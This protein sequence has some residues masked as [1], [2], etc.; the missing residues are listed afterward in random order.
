[1][2]SPR[3]AERLWEGMADLIESVTIDI[4]W[5]LYG[6]YYQGFAIGCNAST[7]VFPVPFF[8]PG[9]AEN[10]VISFARRDALIDFSAARCY[11]EYSHAQE[12]IHRVFGVTVLV[13][14]GLWFGQIAGKLEKTFVF[15]WSGRCQL[16]MGGFL[17]LWL[18]LLMSPLHA[19]STLI[20]YVW[21]DWQQQQHIALAL[22]FLAA[23]TSETLVSRVLREERAS[24]N[25]HAERKRTMPILM[26]LHLAWVVNLSCSGLSFLFHPQANTSHMAMHRVLGLCVIVGT[27]FMGLSKILETACN[28]D[29]TLKFYWPMLLPKLCWLAVTQILL[30]FPH[31]P[32]DRHVGFLPRCQPTWLRT[33]V[34]LSAAVATITIVG[35][36]VCAPRCTPTS[37]IAKK[38]EVVEMCRH[39]EKDRLL[40]RCRDNDDVNDA[41]RWWSDEDPDA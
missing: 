13:M 36:G 41:I 30:F 22:S 20:T 7:A 21:A 8:Q 3:Q 29:E 25:V 11:R 23:G 1:M 16:F 24:G 31:H 40:S 28:T 27:I 38:N 4:H 2:L 12:E 34:Y 39:E 15:L 10:A 18:F 14:V 37:T 9:Y 6:S 19:G 32:E 5:F 33:F 26:L 17:I 35:F